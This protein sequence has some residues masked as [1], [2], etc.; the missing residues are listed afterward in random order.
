MTDQVALLPGRQQILGPFAREPSLCEYGG[1]RRNVGAPR[2]TSSSG[3]RISGYGR[4][5]ARRA[6]GLCI[7]RD[8]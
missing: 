1:G 7:E 3:A 5:I 4:P 6:A 8:L 2:G